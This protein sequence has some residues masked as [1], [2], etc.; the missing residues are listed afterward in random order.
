MVMCCGVWLCV[1]CD[2]VV[3]KEEEVMV[4]VVV[5]VVMVVEV[6]VS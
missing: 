5:M 3:E 6:G 2:G 4:M 1:A